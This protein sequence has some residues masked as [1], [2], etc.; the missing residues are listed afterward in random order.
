MNASL[1][2]AVRAL[3]ANKLRTALTMLGIIIGA[4]AVIALMSIGRGAQAQITQQIQSLG[5]NLLFVR[6]GSTNQQGVRTAAGN[7]ATLTVDDADAIGGLATVV[8][9]R[10]GTRAFWVSLTPT[11]RSAI[12]RWR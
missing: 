11:P 6:P 5:T 8:T 3:G 9:G 12:R 7:A 2:V 10:I 4:A 1:R